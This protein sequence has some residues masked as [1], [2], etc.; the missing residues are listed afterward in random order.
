M[1]RAVLVATVGSL[2]SL[3]A[4]AGESAKPGGRVESASVDPD[5][6]AHCARTASLVGSACSYSTGAMARRVVEQGEAFRYVGTLSPVEP[7]LS[8]DEGQAV[9]PS[10]QVACP[11]QLEGASFV[12]ATELLD[13]LAGAGQTA[14]RLSLT[15]RSLDVDGITYVVLTSFRVVPS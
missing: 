4:W 9:A 2:W 13:T 15:G 7:N 3:G 14:A 5:T 8:V 1:R 6:A 11:F 10:G 12:I